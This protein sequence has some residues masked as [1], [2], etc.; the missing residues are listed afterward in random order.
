MKQ[1]P[2]ELRR[3]PRVRLHRRRAMRR[4]SGRRRRSTRTCGTPARARSCLCAGG[5]PRRLL[6]AGS[7]RAG[8]SFYAK[9]H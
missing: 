4:G 5:Q 9:R 2:R 8:C 3:R 1:S 7:Q 6:P